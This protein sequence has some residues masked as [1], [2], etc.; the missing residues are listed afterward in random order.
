M[1]GLRGVAGVGWMLMA[2]VSA[3]AVAPLPAGLE[4]PVRTV[5]AVGPEGQGNAEAAAAWQRLAEAPAEAVPGLL[6]AMDGANEYAINWLRSAIETAV[7]REA[8][9]GHAV[10]VTALEEVLADLGH[11]PRGRGLAYELI[12]RM[13]PERAKTLLPGFLND[14]GTELRREA[15]AAVAAEA[16]ARAA[17]GDPAAAVTGYR[18]AL[19]Y[20]READQVDV[21]AQKLQDLGETVDL[22]ELLG[23]VTRWQVV[24]PFDNTGGAGFAR[25][26]PPESA[27][28]ASGEYPGKTEPVRWQPFETKD[29]H[30]MV[31][32]NK[33]FSPLKEVTGYAL[34]EFWSDTARPAELRLGCKNGWK[35]WWNGTFLFGRDEYH[36]AAEMDQYR[37][38]VQIQAGKNVLLVKCCQ[39]EQ[40]EEWTKEWE[41]Q[42]RV[43]D[44]QGA[45]IR[46][47]K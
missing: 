5:R 34:T 31:D 4:A 2:V 24:G 22:R 19:T 43:T 6:A 39:N 33:P 29:D 21:L 42:L 27:T 12:A 11:H 15:V 46:S 44:P 13:Q 35:I 32:F 9:A 1:C 25:A 20:A 18:K 30:G 7:Q 37:L 45:P 36:R 40:T 10:S 16:E 17:A 3:A 47:T 28:E 23:W 14:P 38:P 26:F 41:F 8:A